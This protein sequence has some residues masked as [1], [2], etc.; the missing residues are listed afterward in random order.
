MK[1]RVK[2]HRYKTS[3][4]GLCKECGMS[5]KHRLHQPLLWRATHRRSFR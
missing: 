3:V 1:G 4:T 5:P 2:A